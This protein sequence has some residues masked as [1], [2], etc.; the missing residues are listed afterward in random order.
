QENA[1]IAYDQ[2][3]GQLIIIS[4]VITTFIAYLWMQKI[5]KLPSPKRLFTLEIISNE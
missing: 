4:G 5:A 1:K 2:P 3:V